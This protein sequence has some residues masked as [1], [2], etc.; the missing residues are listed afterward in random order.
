MGDFRLTITGMV[1]DMYM[2][3]ELVL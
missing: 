3:D 1:F 2:L